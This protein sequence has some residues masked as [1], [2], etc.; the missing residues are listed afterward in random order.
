MPDARRTALLALTT[1]VAFGTGYSVLYKTYLDTSNPLLAHLP[2]PLGQAHYFA[3]KQNP[4]N[5][6]FIK[7]AWGWTS[8]VFLLSWL[9][10]P[11]SIRTKERLAQ[12]LLATASWLV[13]TSWFF[14][15]SLIERIIVA[16]GGECVIRIPGADHVVVPHELCYTK[17]TVT[18]ASS[19]FAPQVQHMPPEWAVMPRL[20]RGH[21]VSG[22]IFLLTMSILFLVDQLRPSLHIRREGQWSPLHHIAVT[23]NYLLIA[24]WFLATYTTSIY[25]HSPM[26]KASGFVLGILCFTITQLPFIKIRL[27]KQKSHTN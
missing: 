22:H 12:W 13:F 27:S 14:G 25:F 24:I 3:S 26:E 19:S 18:S 21:D 15:P 20:F 7:K 4:L 1:V 11:P 6:H 8:G 2:H 23:A 5:V 9:T 16:S 17:T 10:S